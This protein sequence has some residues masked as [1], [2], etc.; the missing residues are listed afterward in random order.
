M[1]TP[2]V[3]LNRYLNSSLRVM[4]TIPHNCNIFVQRCSP[5]S[6]SQLKWKQWPHPTHGPGTQ[7][8]SPVLSASS[9]PG[10]CLLHPAA[11]FEGVM[12]EREVQRNVSAKA[13]GHTGQC[14]KCLTTEN[15]SEKTPGAPGPHHCTATGRMGRDWSAAEFLLFGW[16]TLCGGSGGVLCST[17]GLDLPDTRRSPSPS[18]HH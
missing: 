12:K 3:S 13:M 2:I 11:S 9:H 1:V 6:D 16:V 14:G 17:P 18:R 10:S 8:H 15:R 5:I 4:T 7:T